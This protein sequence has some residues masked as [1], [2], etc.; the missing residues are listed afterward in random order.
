MSRLAMI[1]LPSVFFPPEEPALIGVSGGRDSVALLHLLAKRGH[2]LIV[3]HLDHA[4]RAESREEARF[5]EGLAAGLGCEFVGRRENVAARAKRTKCSIETAAREARYAF[6][7]KVTRARGVP[8]VFLA[9]HADDQVETFLFNLLRGSGAAGLAAMR[10]Q[11]MRGDL[12]LVRPLL[13]VWREEIEA[14]VAEHGLEF[15]E[16]P[17]NTDRR[18]TRNRVRHE[19]LPLLAQAFGRDV[20]AALLRSAEILRE[21]DAFLAALPELAM[22]EEREPRVAELREL[23]VAIQRRVLLAW[24]RGRGVAEVGFEEVERVRSLLAARVAKVNL[25]GGLHARRRAGRVFVE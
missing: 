15:C 11:S 5:V 2:R 1:Q 25:P 17:S 13:G 16:D 22:A 18:H 9:H 3:C 6:F 20:R 21:E 8:R 14:Y 4:L 10:A 7:A 19:I 12:E 23:P 24:L